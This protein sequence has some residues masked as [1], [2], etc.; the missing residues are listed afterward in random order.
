[1]TN[2]DFYAFC[3]DQ[4]KV[5]VDPERRAALTVVYNFMRECGVSKQGVAGFLEHCERECAKDGSS[6]A[7]YQWIRQTFEGE[8]QYQH[9]QARQRFLMLAGLARR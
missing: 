4:R 5:E 8:G 2:R 6:P 7:G 1:M 9:K 3:R